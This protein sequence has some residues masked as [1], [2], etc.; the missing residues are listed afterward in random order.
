M[1][2]LREARESGKLNQFIKEHRADSKGDAATFTA[3][4]QAMAGKSKPVPETSCEP[5]SDDCSDTQTP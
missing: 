2:T 1:T 5:H 3:T 4:L